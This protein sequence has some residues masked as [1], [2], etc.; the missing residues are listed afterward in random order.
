MAASRIT[1]LAILLIYKWYK[2]AESQKMYV[3]INL[4]FVCDRSLPE[5]SGQS[6][7]FPLL[8]LYYSVLGCIFSDTGE[9]FIQNNGSHLDRGVGSI[10][11][12]KQHNQT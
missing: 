12:P 5:R 4:A 11:L 6:Y 7:V 10:T 1:F 3:S 2:L 9:E 8:C